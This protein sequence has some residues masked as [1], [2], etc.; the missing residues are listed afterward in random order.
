MT[1]NIF[2]QKA[3]TASLALATVLGGLTLS[4]TAY[5]QSDENSNQIEEIVITGSRIPQKSN[6]VSS[7]PVTEVSAEEFLFR[8][9]VRVEDLLND[10]PQTFASNNS[11]DSNGAVGT[12]SVD[13][14]GLG[15]DRTLVLVDGKRLVRG[16][17]RS[18]GGGGDLNQ[19]PDFL[20]KKVEVLTGGA[21]AAYGSDAIAGVVNFILNDELDGVLIDYQYSQYQHSNDNSTIQSIVSD[22]GFDLPS[23]SVSDGDVSAF[24][25]AFG[26]DL[27][28]GKGHMT[29]YATY[30]NVDPILQGNRDF[31]SCALTSSNASCGGSSTL[32]SGRFTDFGDVN[33]GRNGTIQNELITQIGQDAF[34][35]LGEDDLEAELMRVDTA[36]SAANAS[37]AA[38]SSFDL[39]T[40]NGSDAFTD[41]VASDLYNFAP[42]NYYQRPDKKISIGGY[43]NYEINDFVETY[44][45]VGYTRDETTSQI[46]PSGNF[47][48]TDDI[49]CGNP[50]L[51]AAQFEEIC[52]QYGLTDTQFFSDVGALAGFRDEDG[53][54]VSP[55]FFIGRRNLEGGPR[56]DTITHS[57]YRAVLGF[58]GNINDEWSYDASINFA[59]TDLS[60]VYLNDLSSTRI[61][62]ALDVV[63]DADGNPVCRT[64]L[65]G[66]DSN[67]VPWNLF[68]NNGNQLATDVRDGVT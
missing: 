67:C 60:N 55:G 23:S 2:K 42:L 9:V 22:R 35:A 43:G 57:T 18:S 10:L 48:V 13:L 51:S 46:A 64:A 7:S 25:F 52:G 54:T 50:L 12:A 56:Q 34:D 37:F 28:D 11:T 20:V 38:L 32:P 5:S 62:R 41:R 53:E 65:N 26:S 31:S 17:P 19:I 58:R 47:F 68:T 27:D 30:R 8:G 21:S 3:L 16:S 4:S 29:L 44:A 66:V 45:Q 6:L 40:T 61:A 14:R 49:S 15:V 59:R 36:L 1:N 33:S 39:I 63:A 24:S